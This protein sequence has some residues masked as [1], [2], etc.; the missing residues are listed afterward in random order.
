MTIALKMVP[1]DI[2]LNP[3]QDNANYF[4]IRAAYYSW[5]YLIRKAIACYL[6]IDTSELDIG[7]HIS[8][9]TRNPEVFIVEKLE[10][11]SG[12]C[13]YLS[14]RKYAQVPTE[15][16]LQPL[17]KGGAIYDTLCTPDHMRNCT[18]SCYDCIRDYSNQQYHMILDWRLGL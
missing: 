14:G 12:Y 18:S 9:K 1:R 4:A 11:G 13:N 16:L 7:Y 8:I 3:L 17:L 5:G 15:A 6:D 2:C 10:N